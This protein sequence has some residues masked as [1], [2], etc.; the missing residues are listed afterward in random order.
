MVDRVMTSR[1][2]KQHQSAIRIIEEAVQ[3]LRAAPGRLLAGYYLGSVPFVLGLMYFWADMSRS[4]SAGRHS[5]LAALG[6]AILYVWMKFWQSVFA[7]QLRTQ[8]TGELRSRWPLSRIFSVAA[9]QSLIQST[10]F[11]VLPI[12]GVILIPYGVCYAF[13]QNAAAYTEEDPQTVRST[14]K[15]AWQQATLWPRQNH[16]L[17]TIFGL[18]GLVIFLNLSIAAYI[19]PQMAKTLFGIDSV[20]TLS[21]LRMIL[22]TTFWMAMLGMTYLCLDPFI[23][24]VY[25]LRCF[26]GS[27]LKTGEDLK[28]ELDHLLADVKYIVSVLAIMVVCSTPIFCLAGQFSVVSPKELDRSIEETL[29]R[30]EFTWRMPRESAQN[31]EPEDLGP[32]EAAIKWLL[33]I[34]SAGLR[35]LGDWI[36]LLIEWLENYLPQ[37]DKKQ[38]GSYK[39]W[40]TPVRAAIFLLLVFLITIIALVFIRIWRRHRNGTIEAAAIDVAPLPDLNNEDTSADDLPAD[41]WFEMAENLAAKGDLRLSMRALYL[42]TLAYLSD[43]EMITIEI[44]KSNREYERELRRRGHKREDLLAMFSESLNIFERVWYGM[45]H[46]PRSEYDEFAAKQKRILEFAR[47]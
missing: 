13:Y 38:T 27:A 1:P 15:W 16:L 45:Y 10:R 39:N 12:A 20:F 19:V 42:A 36:T 29:E 5:T 21:G 9:T 26:Y 23:K 34:I 6:L 46:I 17:I 8:L 47:H 31:E 25:A 33:D 43:Q 3:L 14:F 44:F 30:P 22:N 11:F 41:R 24:T 4:A 2:K 35:T 7:C 37:P 40:I 28:T 18:F 32:I